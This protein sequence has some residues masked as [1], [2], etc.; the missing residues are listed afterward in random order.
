MNS[1]RKWPPTLNRRHNA[2][3]TLSRH[4]RSLAKPWNYHFEPKVFHS[5]EVDGWWSSEKVFY[6]TFSTHCHILVCI[7]E[8]IMSTSNK[9]FAVPFPVLTEF[10]IQKS[11]VSHEAWIFGETFLN[12]SFVT[13]SPPVWIA[14]SKH[15]SSSL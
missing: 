4:P 13:M 10:F 12:L 8:S 2:I 7:V 9:I 14:Y 1:E 3:L 11:P 5:R 15:I 6:N